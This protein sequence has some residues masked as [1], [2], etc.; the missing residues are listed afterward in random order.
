MDKSIES[1][2]KNGFLESNDKIALKLNN[3]YNKKSIHIID[4]FK[5]LFK[6]NFNVLIIT[7]L[8]LLP[9]LF[10]AKLLVM[11]ILMFILLSFFLITDKKILKDL[12]KI[13]KNTSSYLYLKSF[14]TW[15]KKQIT[16]K[17]QMS[18]YIYP[19]M[20]ITVTSEVWSSREN[21]NDILGDYQPYMIHEIPVYW[22][23]SMLIIIVVLAIFGRQFYKWDLNLVYGRVLK[24]LDELIKDMEDLRT[25]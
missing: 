4:R 6:I 1:I 21:F 16:I 18:R 12:N 19:Y 11:A 7:S 23:L 24:E 14:D 10:F 13:D 3:L 2:W 9:I 15:L 8:V 5:R 20:F 22:V 17:M 25:G